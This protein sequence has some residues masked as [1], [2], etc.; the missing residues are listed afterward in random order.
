[1]TKYLSCSARY[2]RLFA[3][4]TTETSAL[5][6]DAATL[7]RQKKPSRPKITTAIILTR[8]PII[9]RTPSLFE[10]AYWA[11]QSRI[12]RA[13]H[14]P[15]PS[16]FYFK[17]GSPLEAR[18]NAEEMARERKAFG[19]PFGMPSAEDVEEKKKASSTEEDSSG[20]EDE[21][22]MSRIHPADISGDVKSLDRKG[23][24]HLYLVVKTK[25]GW[26]FPEGKDGVANGELLHEVC[27]CLL[28]LFSWLTLTFQAAGRDLKTVCGPFMDTWIVSR[29]PIGVYN[30]PP[31]STSPNPD[32][33]KVCLPFPSCY[34]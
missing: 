26:V 21:E 27:R 12:Q 9:T 28:C 13:L 20:L 22:N 32:E 17:Q 25:D 33:P 15:F 19:K 1:M 23:Q 6:Q 4:A 16:E 3:T 7:P 14:N 8:A 18:F 11:Y 24:R 34:C 30:P 29:Q 5:A 10:R 31:A 2:T